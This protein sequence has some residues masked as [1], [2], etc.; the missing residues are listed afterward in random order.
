MGIK[1]KILLGSIS[2]IHSNWL[3]YGAGCLISHC[4]SIPE[5][6]S[7][8]EFLDPIYK[9][10]SNAEYHDLLMSVD[11]LGLTCY[12]WNQAYNDGLA[13]YYKSVVPDGVV[14]FGGPQ[15]PEDAAD[16]RAYTAEREFLDHSIE[17]LGEIAFS[18]WLLD[19][20]RTHATLTTMPSPYTDGVFANLLAT[21]EMFK[22]SF[23]TNRGC[24]YSC[25]FCDWGGQA[26]SK[27]TMFDTQDVF[28][29]ID[30]IYQQTNI[31]ELEILDANFG[32]RKED[33]DVVDHMIQQQ[34]LNN[35][36]L[37]ISYSGLAKNGSRHLPKI[38]H[39]IFSQIPIDQRNLKISF[40]THTK[41][42]LA[43][44]SRSNIDNT[45]LLPLI[46]QYK[47][48]NIP[49]TS[50]M[51]IAMP[52]ET[53]DSWL[54]TLEYNFHTLGI[55]YVRTYILHIVANTDMN[56]QSYRTKYDIV[57]K[58][59][60]HDH[61]EV[62]VIASCYSYDIEELVL[63]FKYNWFYHNLIN[64]DIIKSQITN[65]YDDCRAF[66]ANLDNMPLFKSMID[67]QSDL[68][69]RIFSAGNSHIYAHR[70]HMWFATSLRLDE[71]N[72]MIENKYQIEQELSVLYNKPNL[73][74]QCDNVY[75]SVA[76]VK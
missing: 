19:I 70:E 8:F 75:S 58:K 5:I 30:Y 27:L 40:Q 22:V 50:E 48:Q 41:E 11:I 28:R 1:K 13:K 56:K 17:G 45:R 68:V 32:I 39:K 64:T 59:V 35:N 36:P 42:V 29:T 20:P 60:I 53:A 10:S 38:L 21:G 14:I 12:V 24:P 15:I 71:I 7:K 54:R 34:T 67:K 43:A 46:N 6:N 61:Q 31:N 18:Q 2:I 73:L 26:K 16:R 52:G 74:W 55:D 47:Q 33:V 65:V 72:I 63:M 25:A 9:A 51:I 57:T 69:R 49:T 37:K 66:I 44:V 62:E 23:E 4:Q 76:T 3:P